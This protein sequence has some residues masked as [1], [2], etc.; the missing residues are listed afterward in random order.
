MTIE[1]TKTREQSLTELPRKATRKEWLGLAVLGMTS[2]VVAI[3]LFVML[4]AL[5]KISQDLHASGTQLLWITDMYGFLLAGFLI[6]MGTLGD[7]IGRRKV[8]LLGSAAFGAT[9]FLVAFSQS[10]EMLIF[11]RALL[12]VAGAM[13]APAAL[14]LIRHMFADPE[15]NAR[16]ISI[17]LSCLI[18]GSIVGPLVGGVL[19]EHFWWGSVFLVG[20]PPMVIALLGGRKFLPEYKNPDAAQLHFPSVF[21]SLAAILSLIYGMTEVAAYGWQVLPVVA[22]LVGMVLSVVF[23]CQ[24][25]TLPDPLLDVTLFKKPA[26]TLMLVAMLMNTM[27]PGGVMVLSTQYLQLVAGLSPLQ[28]GLWMIPAM[29]ASILGF[30]VSPSLARTIRPAYLIAL[31]LVCSIIGLLILCLTNVGGDLVAL[32]IGFALFNLGSGPLVTLGT[33]IVIGSVAPQKAG[34]AA[35]VSQTGNEFGFA[36]GVAVVGSIGAFVYRMQTTTLPHELSADATHAVQETLATAVSTAGN[37]PGKLGSDVLSIARN[38]FVQEYHTVALLSAGVLAIIAV[39]IVVM[40]KN[41]PA[42]AEKN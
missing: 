1:T 7:H 38:A 13:I 26:F 35:A 31:G 5:P 8:L 22:L 14:S 16:A 23:V 41:L 24:Q 36:L 10:A 40:L 39:V 3:D 15:E 17:W 37:L 12:G 42:M 32:L 27:F 28:A 21:L 19:L 2:L 29:L 30:Q 25:R 9:S 6:T 18:G 11:A 4:L 20:I 33:G 34:A